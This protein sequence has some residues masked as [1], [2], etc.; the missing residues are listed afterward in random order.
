MNILNR[1]FDQVVWIGSKEHRPDRYA[2]M[3]AELKKWGIEARH[4]NAHWKPGGSGNWGCSASHRSV[5]GLICAMEWRRTLILEDD[6]TFVDSSWPEMFEAVIPEIPDD[7]AFL[8]IGGGY[9]EDPKRR[10]NGSVIQTNAMMTTSSYGI[11]LAMARHCAPFVGGNSG[12]DSQ[13]HA[14]QREFPSYC[15]DPRLCV[16]RDS[17]SDLA[18]NFSRNHNSMLDRAHVDRLDAGETDGI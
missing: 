9:A 12:I 11:S 1:Y 15:L 10:I 7:W 4:F 5:L 3:E 16:Q 2:E 14:A 6:N 8:F 18:D 17:W 13:Y